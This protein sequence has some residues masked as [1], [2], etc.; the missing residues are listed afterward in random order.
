MIAPEI[1]PVPEH[2]VF[3]SLRRREYICKQAAFEKLLRGPAVTYKD[4]GC[5]IS[6]ERMIVPVFSR[7]AV[8]LVKYGKC[9]RHM[10]GR[11]LS[12]TVN[13]EVFPVDLT[14]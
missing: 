5:L 2:M 7:Y 12:F 9:R 13:L 11:M 1:I 6:S 3:Y 10:V 4:D 14:E 8:R